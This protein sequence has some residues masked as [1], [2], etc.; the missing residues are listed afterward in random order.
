MAKLPGFFEAKSQEASG[1]KAKNVY[2]GIPLSFTYTQDP[3]KHSIKKYKATLNHQH[4]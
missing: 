3:Q 4:E 2:R 1:S